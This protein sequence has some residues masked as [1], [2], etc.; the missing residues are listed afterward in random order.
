MGEGGDTNH[1]VWGR[2]G[3]RGL[4]ILVLGEGGREGTNH[5]SVW[6]REGGGL[7]QNGEAIV[8]E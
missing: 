3:G 2:E 8:F 1:S 7:S 6:G 4:T 5:I